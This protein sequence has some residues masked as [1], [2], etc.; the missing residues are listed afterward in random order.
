LNLLQA[1]QNEFSQKI[2]ELNEELTSLEQNI[3]RNR[4]YLEHHR[5]F[6]HQRDAAVYKNDEQRILEQLETTSSDL[7]NRLPIDAP[8]LFNPELVSKAV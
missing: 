7:A 3:S 8:L 2:D 5:A 1:E 6:V 4:R